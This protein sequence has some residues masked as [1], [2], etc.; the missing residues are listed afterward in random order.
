MKRMFGVEM[1]APAGKLPGFYAQVI[2]KIGDNVNVF[3]RDGQLLIVEGEH[4]R[5]KLNELLTKASMLG[6]EFSLW[7]LPP[8]TEIIH[9]D[10]IGFES[11][12]GHTY[13]YA[14]RVAFFSLDV[15]EGD[16][17]DQWAAL[18]QMKE[19]ILGRIPSTPA[20]L[21]LIDPAHDQLIDGIARAYNISVLWQ[22]K[23]V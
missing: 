20:D 16:D 12:E 5:Q 7:L 2:H 4:D 21:Y 6:E 13:L 19:A 18:E 14:D 1:Q 17:Q 10:D 23:D 11:Q 3:D 8:D 22:D 9:L 15:S